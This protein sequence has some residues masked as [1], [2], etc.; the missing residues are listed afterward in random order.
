MEKVFKTLFVLAILISCV[1]LIV[2]FLFL[3]KLI[4]LFTPEIHL[5]GMLIT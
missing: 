4:L 3:L 5:F 2:G 1:L